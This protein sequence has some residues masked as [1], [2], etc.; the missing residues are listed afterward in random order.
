M[1][2]SFLDVCCWP[3]ALRKRRLNAYSTYKWSIRIGI[4][5]YYAILRY[6]ALVRRLGLGLRIISSQF[7]WFLNNFPIQ[8][9]ALH[10]CLNASV[11]CLGSCPGDHTNPL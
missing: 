5:F 9:Y 7:P 2:L 8:G 4:T 11:K 10:V 6:V 3:L 1:R